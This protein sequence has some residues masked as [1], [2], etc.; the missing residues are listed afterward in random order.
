MTTEFGTRSAFLP[1]TRQTLLKTSFWLS[2][3]LSGCSLSQEQPK[4]VIEKLVTPPT[5][6]AN[7][8]TEPV[9]VMTTPLTAN[10]MFRLLAAE[11]LA[12][13]GLN[14][15]AAHVYL[16]LAQDQPD[17]AIAQRAYELATQSA[18][19]KLLAAAT[20]ANTK[21]N[22]AF[23]ES[24]QVQILLALRAKNPS[25]ALSNW[26]GF[27]ARSRAAGLSEKEIFLS[28]ATLGQEELDADV[29][30]IFAEGIVQRHPEAYMAILMQVVFAVN[31]ERWQSAF[32]YLWVGLRRF[33]DQAELVQLLASM[34]A[35]Q[36]DEKGINWLQGYI[37][38]NP[39]D[40]AIREQLA[41]ALVA[42]KRLEEAKTLFLS[43]QQAKSSI[44]TQMSIGLIELELNRPVEAE[45]WIRP[46][47]EEPALREMA[48]YYLA[49]SLFF[50][51]KKAEAIALWAEVKGS[52]YGLDALIWRSQAMFDMDQKKEALALLAAFEVTS[53]H[54]YQRW[55]RVQVRL[56][57]LIPDIDNA[58]K[59]LDQAIA[60]KPEVSSFWRDRANLR[61]DSGN[62]VGFEQDMRQ[63]LSLNDQD[64]EVLNALGYFLADT[65]QSLPEARQL[66]E[67]ANSLSPNKHHILDSLGWLAFRE[68]KL[69]QAQSLL[70]QAYQ[71]EADNEVLLHWL[72]V[73]LALG[74]QTQA[75]MLVT[76]EGQKFPDDANLQQLMQKILTSQ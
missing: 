32:E 68:G 26:E 46:L 21:A 69:T 62:I 30:K 71:L 25:E 27:F 33:P 43:I 1:Q 38:R 10:T 15:P 49:Q 18:N 28:A 12:A 6:A 20:L 42:N 5:V 75:K 73:L 29:L 60:A 54:D 37:E 40:L 34:L 8:A 55:I 17:Q 48:S 4:I 2:M 14:E 44:T 53:E 16:E 56:S 52:D 36:P 47:V 61:Y 74:D 7:A 31:H 35:R 64:P 9:Q 41:R 45:A 39:K 58:Q 72:T 19:S 76:Q 11:T 50:Q 59:I 51:D 23:L 3:L 13:R 57:M 65:N 24:W 67:K 63:A 70:A 22:P 66:L